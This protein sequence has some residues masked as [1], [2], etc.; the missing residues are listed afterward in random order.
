MRLAV[1]GLFCHLCLPT[2]SLS[3][4]FHR[5]LSAF[6]SIC[7]FSQSRHCWSIAYP[8]LRPSLLASLSQ[9]TRS[10]II[11]IHA[12]FGNP[13]HHCHLCAGAPTK[14]HHIAQ[15]L[16]RKETPSSLQEIPEAERSRATRRTDQD[17][18][19]WLHEHRHH[20]QH[21]AGRESH[22][23]PGRHDPGSPLGQ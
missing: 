5:S 12:L 20:C 6:N 4:P 13:S 2:C 21:G 11:L 7:H 8:L 23:W 17:V 15:P 16:N 18:F 19:A 10:T 1:L 14:K 3:F 22:R 9:T